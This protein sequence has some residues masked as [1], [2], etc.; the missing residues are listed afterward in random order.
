MPQVNCVICRQEFYA[1]PSW[2]KKGFGKYC[3]RK[4]QHEGRKNGQMINCFICEK[5]VYKAVKALKHSKSKKY[6]CGK[7]CQTIWR[8]TI[9]FIG[10]NHPNWKHGE[11]IYRNRLINNNAI[12]KICKICKIDDFRILA[13]HHLDKNKKNNKLENLIWLCHNCHFLAHHYNN[14]DINKFENMETLV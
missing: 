4:C 2:L 6:F 1:K 10:K 8:N 11:Y 14:I 12:L 13:V 7:S 9:V 5:R 3:S